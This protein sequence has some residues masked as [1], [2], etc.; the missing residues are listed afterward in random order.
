MLVCSSG[1][2]TFGVQ[3]IVS[4]QHCQG[5]FTTALVYLSYLGGGISKQGGIPKDQQLPTGINWHKTHVNEHFPW[6]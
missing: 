3:Q 2:F 5:L 6:L 4:S 1:S